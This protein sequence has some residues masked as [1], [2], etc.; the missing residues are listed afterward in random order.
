LHEAMEQ[1]KISIAKA[2]I[3]TTFQTKAS[4]LAA[5][6]PKFG[7]FDPNTPPAAQFDIPQ[8]LLS[9]F[10]LIFAIR[11]ILDESHDRKLVEHIMIGHMAGASR[12]KVA[13][14]SMILPVI[15]PDLL[16]KYIAYARRT[17][18]P[19]LTNEASEKIKEFYLDLRQMGKKSNT[20]PVTARQVEGIIRLAEASAKVRLSKKVELQDA[21]RAVALVTFVLNDIFMDKETG[22]IDSDIV[23][24]GQPK[25][26]VD[27]IRTLMNIITSL[28][29][30]FDIVDVDD[31]VKECAAVN[32][33]EPTC[34]KMVDDLKK[35][36]DLYEPKPGQVKTA[37]KKSDW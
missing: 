29:K 13:D 19:Q 9:R 34:R 8:T 20:F 1:Q 23:N 24:I 11:D 30:Q 26:K 17:V 14:D 21:E 32:I 33:D 36:G 7:R 12:E 27:K 22:L 25:S 18:F 10:D 6:N 3:L 31:I 15:S 28:Q 37:R 2:G 4:V 35:N 16:R 5:A